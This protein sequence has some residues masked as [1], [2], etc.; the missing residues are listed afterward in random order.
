[1]DNTVAVTFFRTRYTTYRLQLTLWPAKRQNHRNIPCFI[2]TNLTHIHTFFLQSSIDTAYPN[3][4]YYPLQCYG[5]PDTVLDRYSMFAFLSSHFSQNVR[6]TVEYVI[7]GCAAVIITKLLLQE[8]SSL[9]SHITSVNWLFLGASLLCFEGYF[10]LRAVSWQQVLFGLGASIPFK[11][12]LTIWFIS[13]FSRYVPGNVWSVLSRTY[14]MEKAGVAKRITLASMALE[15]LLLVGSAGLFAIIFII[16]LP[17][18][19][20]HNLRWLAIMALPLLVPLLIPSLLEKIANRLLHLLKRTPVTFPIT[21]GRIVLCCFLHILAWGLYGLGSYLV[22]IALSWHP[23][24]SPF[25]LISSFVLAWLAGYV[26]FIT[27]MGLGVREGA[28]IAVLGPLITT[29]AASVIALASRLW[30]VIAELIALAVISLN[31]I[32]RSGSN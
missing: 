13:E 29:G 1:M 11:Q 21:S 12:A 31:Q 22:L 9:L 18:P 23:A 25:W 2:S 24:A 17:F 26:S 19:D 7:L 15:A 4:D 10:L 27:P 6:R 16:L 14:A 32:R 20:T 30:L 28:V 5:K 3:K 8:G